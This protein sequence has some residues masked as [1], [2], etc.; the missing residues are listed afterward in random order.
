MEFEGKDFNADKVKLYELVR[1]KITKI[2]VH[3]LL[4]FGLPNL[5]SFP[6][7]RRD[8]YSLDEIELKEKNNCAL[9]RKI[10]QDLIKKEHS[11]IQ[12]NTTA[13]FNV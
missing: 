10:R 2:Y 8:N 7:M 1:Q 9:D 5:E 12:E 6:F 11:H 4:K 13:I 3:E